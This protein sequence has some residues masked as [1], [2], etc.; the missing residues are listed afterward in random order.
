MSM[1][2]LFNN[3]GQHIFF[4]AIF[5]R[6]ISNTLI[7]DSLHILAY[8]CR[9]WT[10]YYDHTMSMR[11]FI[12]YSSPKF[13]LCPLCYQD[14]VSHDTSSS[15]LN[16]RKERVLCPFQ[17][18]K[19]DHHIASQG[20][21]TGIPSNS[22]T[23]NACQ[24]ID[25]TK[26]VMCSTVIQL[27]SSAFS[28]LRGQKMRE[29]CGD[30][31]S[32]VTVSHLERPARGVKLGFCFSQ[33]VLAPCCF[34]RLHYVTRAHAPPFASFWFLFPLVFSY[35]L[36]GPCLLWSSM[37]LVEFI[38]VIHQD[39]MVTRISYISDFIHICTCIFMLVKQ[40]GAML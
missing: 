25:P 5:L 10:G 20:L 17:T 29:K 24:N 2:V 9:I 1:C 28:P 12:S 14:M 6:Q 16:H 31:F 19:L 3:L 8:K 35:S 33:L 22:Y 38:C 7:L 18:F 37:T 4:I 27:I 36:M 21:S 11:V 26:E 39:H 34:V 32:G 15:V 40:G 30:W 23:Q 13:S